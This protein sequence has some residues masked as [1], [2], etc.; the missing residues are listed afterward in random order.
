MIRLPAVAA[1]F[2]VAL[3]PAARGQEKEYDPVVAGQ[4]ISKNPE[5]SVRGRRVANDQVKIEIVT[6]AFKPLAA[7]MARLVDDDR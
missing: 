2:V 3:A 4:P 7:I 6:M 5:R 1:A